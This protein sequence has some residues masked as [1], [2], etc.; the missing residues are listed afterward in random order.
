MPTP[1]KSYK[2]K[3]AAGASIV[4]MIIAA[5][6]AVEG[7]YVNNPKD[8]GGATNHGVTE[9]VAR[10]NDYK[11]HMRDLPKEFAA[12]IAY[13]DYIKAP[14]YEPLLELSPTLAHKLIDIGYNAGPGRSSRWLQIAINSLNRGG[15]DYADIA[16]DGRVGPATINAYKNLAKRRGETKACELVLKV[17]EGQQAQHYLSLRH[18]ETF[19]IGWVDHRLGNVS[20][21][22]CG[23]S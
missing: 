7:G 23:K 3:G 21:A 20:V 16:V 17:L 14:G 13:K 4:A 8:P 11:G 2:K 9:A 12:D 1:T 10:K 5:V 18:L 15:Q 6:F 22:E 19:M